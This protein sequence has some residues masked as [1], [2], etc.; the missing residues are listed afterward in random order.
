MRMRCDYC[1]A[2]IQDT[3]AVCPR[4]AGLNEHLVTPAEGWPETI[5][6]LKRFCQD[7]NVPLESLRFFIGEDYREPK[8]YGIYRDAA[9]GNVVVY[10]NKADGTR[11]VRYRGD[12]EAYAVNEIWEKMRSEIANQRNYQARKAAAAGGGRAPKGGGNA[13]RR[14]TVWQVVRRTGL[15]LLIAFFALGFVGCVY[16]VLTSPDTGYYTYGDAPYYLQGDDWYRY[17]VDA[18]DWRADTAPP[19]S[20]KR[21]RGTS[22]R[23]TIGPTKTPL[24]TSP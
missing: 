9:S 17:D 19:R 13:P 14:R 16:S 22:M 2:W 3:D 20:S 7:H 6:D 5:E 10:K 24:R 11:A 4:C 8:A 1:G 18:G 15:G 12:D 23:V 21:T